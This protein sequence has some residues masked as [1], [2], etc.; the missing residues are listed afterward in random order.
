MNL[1]G[2]YLAQL[3]DSDYI[4]Y[5]KDAGVSSVAFHP[6][7]RMAVSTSN[8]GDFKIW[9]SHDEIKKNIGET[10]KNSGWLCHS[11]GSYKSLSFAGK[12]DYLVTVSGGLQPQLSVCSMSKLSVSWSYKL[13]VEDV[14]CAVDASMFAVVVV[15]KSCNNETTVLKGRDGV[16]LLFNVTDP[17]PVA[18]WSVRK[19]DYYFYYCHC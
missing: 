10:V 18:T 7:R 5:E 14:A 4:A 17:L 11:V 1:T 16:I 6:S 8:G 2:S 12:S 13:Q 3:Y 15:G 19:E 9:V